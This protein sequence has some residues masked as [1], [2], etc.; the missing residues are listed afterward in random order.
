MREPAFL[1][2]NREKWQEYEESLFGNNN[3]SLDPGRLEELYIQLTDDLAYARTFYPKSNT[4]KYLNG[5]A[6]RTYLLIYKN[7]NTGENRLK[8][9]LTVDLPL[10][11]FHS[12]K[13]L[14]FTFGVFLFFV[15]MGWI[16]TMND[17][18][19]ARTVLGD[20]Y[21]DMTIRNIEKG[22]PADVYRGGS[23]VITF[24]RIAFNNMYVM[25]ISFLY[26]II[27]GLGTI[28]ILFTN[29]IMVGSFF[30]F[31]ER[32]GASGEAWPIILIH[33]TLEI[34]AIALAGTAGLMMGAGLLFPGTYKRL[35]ALRRNARAG[36]KMMIGL[37]PVITL[38]AFLEGYITR[39]T[40]MHIAF[41]MVIILASA[42]FLIWYYWVYPAQVARK[43][44]L[45]YA[46]LDYV[47]EA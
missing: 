30:A 18:S 4:V 10:I 21:I 17:E 34:T 25:M 6:A 38:A 40:D 12:R 14:L 41:K 36:I 42:A 43:L 46:N 19:M 11:Y 7:K 3:Q 22:E 27:A 29:G 13:Y 31:F 24:L 44:G 26:G 23:A 15:A 5:L 16:L 39:L 28:Y 1:H 33:G 35:H 45:E 9:F 32:Y 20:D 37:I 2:K 47:I 8:R